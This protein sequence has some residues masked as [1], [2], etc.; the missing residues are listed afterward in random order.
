MSEEIKKEAQ[1]V[2]LNPEE[3]GGVAGGLIVDP[4]N[5]FN[6]MIVDD[7]TGEVIDKRWY[8]KDAVRSADNHGV[9]REIITLEEYKKRF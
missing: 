3:L 6:Y 4:G 9:S 2:E 1:D 7:T 5:F 8:S